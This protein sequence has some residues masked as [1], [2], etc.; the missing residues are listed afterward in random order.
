M[1]IVSSSGFY[2]QNK[3]TTVTIFFNNGMLDLCLVKQIIWDLL[4]QRIRT[5][6]VPFIWESFLYCKF[7]PHFLKKKTRVIL[8]PEKRTAHFYYLSCSTDLEIALGIDEDE[9]NDELAEAQSEN[10]KDDQYDVCSNE[11]LHI[12]IHI[13]ALREG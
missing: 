4:Y 3:I 5:I 9:W 11:A 12:A 10:S 1:L 7:H 8:N 2:S 13:P 6:T